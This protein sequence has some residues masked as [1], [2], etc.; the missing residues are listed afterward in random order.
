[1]GNV[2]ST[3]VEASRGTNPFISAES[4]F[5]VPNS[6]SSS[7]AFSI[8]SR[9][10]ASPLQFHPQHGEHVEI[11]PDG[12]VAR[13]VRSYCKGIVFSSRP[14]ELY[15]M[16]CFRIK[17][18]SSK[19]QQWSGAL[20]IGLTT[21]N[22]AEVGDVAS[23]LYLCP[24]L[25]SRLGF[26]A[27]PLPES[28]AG[29]D[30]VV[31]FQCLENGTI[32]FGVNGVCKGIAFD[33]S[34][35]VALRN[36]PIWAV[37]DIY[38][39]T[40]AIELL[41]SAVLNNLTSRPTMT[42]PGRNILMGLKHRQVLLRA[43]DLTSPAA[44]PAS[45]QSASRTSTFSPAPTQSSSSPAVV[46]SRKE[47]TRFRST[48]FSSLTL[49]P[50]RFYKELTGRNV[51]LVEEG[52]SA[53]LAPGEFNNGYVFL[54]NTIPIN[55]TLIVRIDENDWDFDG[56]LAFGLTTCSPTALC[57]GNLPDDADSL[58]DRP[59]YWIVAKDVATRP[60][61]DDEFAFTIKRDGAV[62]ISRNNNKATNFLFVDS[63]QHFYIFFELYGTTRQISLLGFSSTP[64]TT[65]AS[66]RP[67]VTPSRPAVTSTPSPS[68]VRTTPAPRRTTTAVFTTS[69]TAPRPSV[70]TSSIPQ[71]S[72]NASVSSTSRV[73]AGASISSIT[74]DLIDL[75]VDL[76]PRKNNSGTAQKGP[77]MSIGGAGILNRAASTAAATGNVM[78]SS[79]ER[80]ASLPTAPGAEE[81]CICFE[82]QVNSV[83]YTC[84]HQVMCYECAMS[85]FRKGKTCPICRS[86]IKDIIRTYRT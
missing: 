81:C 34:P 73:T 19:Q 85:H 21:H 75:T 1:M 72:L 44:T 33:L 77:T 16:V 25:T 80:S 12:T 52:R 39:T 58:L 38:G 55:Q 31:H 49:R 13:R 9:I 43:E 22:P 29:L 69:S 40:V 30:K 36:V 8:P 82:N 84:G 42:S 59:E 46:V 17:E 78:R 6:L 10:P 54:P 62:Q 50:V 68:A 60:K 51:R 7:A 71:P 4:D 70:S 74:R 57:Q 35:F 27:K 61:K 56:G 65:T 32:V 26:W 15:E 63:S 11:S 20:R 41:D 24:D 18:Q 66:S 48:H 86:E 47:S 37:F 28:C 67:S 45:A 53:R 2:Q 5:T 79:V 23:T 76:P 64:P 3:G 14:L 83:V